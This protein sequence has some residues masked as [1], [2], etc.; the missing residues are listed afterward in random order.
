MVKDLGVWRKDK[1]PWKSLKMAMELRKNDFFCEDC[2]ASDQLKC[3]GFQRSAQ[4]RVLAALGNNREAIIDAT[5]S[6]NSNRVG[7][8]WLPSSPHRRAT[9][10]AP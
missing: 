1:D 2:D 4:R 6:T 10:T 5:H 8:T 7:G 9:Q 3:V